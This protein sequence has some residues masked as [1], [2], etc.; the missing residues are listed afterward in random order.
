MWEIYMTA[1]NLHQRPALL[2][3]RAPVNPHPPSATYAMWALASLMST[4]FRDMIEPLYEKTKEML[5]HLSLEA[6]E[7]EQ[8]DYGACSSMGACCN[9]RIYA[10]ISPTG[11]DERW[12]SFSLGPG[13]AIS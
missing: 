4:Q 12:P 2:G 1:N 9:I 6:N 8:L 3:P 5:E 13:H 10:N 7:K 11:V